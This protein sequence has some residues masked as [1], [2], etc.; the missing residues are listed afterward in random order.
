M[1][2]KCIKLKR[3]KSNLINKLYLAEKCPLKLI[4]SAKLKCLNESHLE[5]RV[6]TWQ[7]LCRQMPSWHRAMR[8]A[9]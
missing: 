4:G 8:N 5:F 3:N 9:L 7:F 6:G 1:R 2:D